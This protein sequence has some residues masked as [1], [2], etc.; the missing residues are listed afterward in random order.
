MSRLIVHMDLDTFFVSYERRN[1]SELVGK[2]I[3]IGGGNCGVVA[4]Y[5]YEITYYDTCSAPMLE[6]AGIDE[7]YPD[8]SGIEHFFGT[9]KWITEPADRVVKKKT[10][11]PILFALSNHKT[12]SQIGARELKAQGHIEIPEMMIRFFSESSIGPENS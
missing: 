5:S 10:G 6:K 2:P 4:S 3:S 11:F 1:N 12:V 8:L 7:Y 9:Y